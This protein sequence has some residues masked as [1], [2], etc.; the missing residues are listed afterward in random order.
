MLVGGTEDAHRAGV[1][2]KAAVRLGDR[3]VGIVEAG[4]RGV[5]ARIEARGEGKHGHAPCVEKRPTIDH[6]P[7]MPSP[8]PAVRADCV[9]KHLVTQWNNI[10]DPGPGEPGRLNDGS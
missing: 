2:G 9:P 6:A 10:L 7:S 5:Q 4:E 8:P 3:P 1:G